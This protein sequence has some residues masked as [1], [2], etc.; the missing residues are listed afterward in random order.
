[1]E[2]V[3]ADAARDAD[4]ARAGNP[5]AAP[6]GTGLRLFAVS[7]LLLF[8]ELACIRWFPAH[9]VFLSFFT[10][11]VL[12]ACFLGMSAG[13]LAARRPRSFITWTA[14][15]LAVAFLSAHGIEY[16]RSNGFPEWARSLA[17]RVSAGS[18][19]L[20]RLDVRVGDT[21]SPEEVFFGAEAVQP[22]VAKFAIPIEVINGSFFVLIALALVGPGQ[23]LGR[24]LNRVPGRVRG[25]TLNILGSLAG[26][27]LFT[28]AS[29]LELSPAW[30]FAVIL[31][32]VA[33][34]LPPAGVA[35]WTARAVVVATCW[36]LAAWT[37]LSAPLLGTFDIFWSPY[38]RIDYRPDT[39]TIL[40]NLMGHQQMESRDVT[41]L[42][43]LLATP[44]A[45]PHLL[46]RDSGGPR[47]QDVLIIGAGSGNDVSQALRWGARHVDA[48]EIDPVIR[49]LGERYH[50]NRPY[51]DPRVEVHQ[52]DGRNFLRSTDRK[53]DL[54]VYALVDSLVLHSS[55][56]NLRLES[57]LF[58][59][60]AFE[61]VKRRLKPDGVFVVCNYFRQGWIV[62]RIRQELSEVFRVAP[63]VLTFPYKA[64]IA[65]DTQGGYTMF[66]AN[67]TEPI[68]R[69][70]AQ[71][72]TYWVTAPPPPSPDS[73]NGFRV[74]EPPANGWMWPFG[75]SQV[76]TPPA[77]VATDDWPFLYVRERAIP[78][79]TLRG[80]A[81]VAVLSALLL[82]PFIPRGEDGRRF[83]WNGRM[84]FLGAG[85]MLIETKAVVHMA[86]LFGSTWIVNSLVFFA[87]LVMILLA[88][89]FVLAVRP[90]RLCGYYAGLF[91]VL[92]VNVLLPLDFF[93]GMSRP[94]QVAGACL[95]AFT[96]ILFAAV[97]FAV[98]F[99]GSQ[100]A[101]RDF[102]TNIAGAMLG[103]LAENTSILLGF[104]HLLAVA[105][106][107]YVLSALTGPRRVEAARAE[108]T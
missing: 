14:P 19:H 65:P 72:Q 41:G 77:G 8:L 73:P 4:A 53:Y 98:S 22:D 47:F 38:Y 71:H 32:G 93:L 96:P 52:D 104:Q 2:N 42:K 60:Q 76:V 25:Y 15:I 85:F 105:L 92:A 83:A 86:L 5:P 100:Q 63:L 89:L 58:T 108:S 69:A 106:G 28:L 45:L 66:F 95:L 49:R 99:A 59:K 12:L 43:G 80:M 24:A 34:L 3:S 31:L 62:G 9:V 57:Y 36:A 39:Q 68:R 97:I 81:I 23:E 6:G 26:I 102:G 61:D 13:C 30:W 74:A 37:G 48:V 70:F 88:N 87:I 56:A 7:V 101:D 21:R 67:G 55:Y 18:L 91:A 107:F 50:P 35:R 78:R 94:A 20:E 10:N 16:L 103:G 64:T 75:L 40:V 29:W 79:L 11:T 1:M 44:Y 51:D 54:I 17:E 27:A 90:R 84:F 82:Y 33:W 46:Q